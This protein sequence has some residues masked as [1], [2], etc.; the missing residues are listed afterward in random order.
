GLR[1]LLRLSRGE[2]EDHARRWFFE[3]FE[4]RV[5][6]LTRQHVRFVDDVDL[7]AV[8]ARRRI[9]G[10]LAQLTG[11]VDSAIRSSVDLDDVEAG[12]AAPN[13]SA[14][15]ALAAWLAVFAEVAALAVE[16]HREYARERRL[17]GAA[18]AAEEIAVCDSA[19]GDRALQ[20]VGDVRLDGD[21]GEG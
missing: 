15:S 13:S 8:V 17:A 16:R 21:R 7:I 3:N 18:R 6:R 9:H 12:R 20:R 10:A 2:D 1:D 4:E 14:R 5:P 11:V 19:A